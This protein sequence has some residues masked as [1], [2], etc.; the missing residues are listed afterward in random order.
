MALVQMSLFSYQ[1][2]MD[3]DVTV[4]L[5]ERRS[6]PH[7]PLGGRKYPVLYLLHGQSRDETS[8]IRGSQ[9]EY[10]LRESDLIVVMPNGYRSYYTDGYYG[11]R[12]FTY[13]T[14]ELPLVIENYFP[15]SDK[16]EDRLIG[17]FS[18]GGYGALLAA[19]RHPD[20]YAAAIS[21]SG[22]V[23]PNL[24][25]GKPEVEARRKA[26]TGGNSSFDAGHIM[27]C[28][29]GPEEQFAGSENDLEALARKAVQAGGPL[30]HIYQCCGRQDF[31]YEANTAFRD[32]LQ[33][34][35]PAI[36]LTYWESDGGHDWTF[37]NREILTALKETQTIA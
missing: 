26:T 32:F 17:G 14:E 31:L 30:P 9:I 2:G 8:W 19:L 13:L 11:H 16:R 20:R 35:T 34:E 5:P 12:H 27:L 3:T 4:L 1:L 25:R 33:K 36:P 29:L 23:D 18:M 7:E 28:N 24:L 22:A 37:W 10:Y 21:L 15:A 6:R